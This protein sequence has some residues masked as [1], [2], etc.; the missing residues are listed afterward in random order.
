MANKKVVADPEEPPDYGPALAF[1]I[2]PDGWIHRQKTEK[3][4]A[5]EWEILCPNIECATS[6]GLFRKGGLR[7]CDGYLRTYLAALFMRKFQS[8]SVCNCNGI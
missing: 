6:I 4:G 7:I 1:Y 3:A 5:N 8:L 2:H